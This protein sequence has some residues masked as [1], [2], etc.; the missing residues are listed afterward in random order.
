MAEFELTTGTIESAQKVLIYGQHG[1][2]KT[3]LAAQL[4]GAVLIDVEGGSGHVDCTRYPRPTTW[5]EL[6]YMVADALKRLQPG[7]TLVI[8]SA[9][10]AERLVFEHICFEHSVASIEGINWGK[11]YVYAADEFK[12][13]LRGLDMLIDKG[14]NVVFVAH[15]LITKFDRPDEQSSY[16]VYGLKLSKHIAP[17]VKEWADAVL[18]CRYK[19]IVIKTEDKKSKA[20]GSGERVMQ[21]THTATIDAKNRWGLD[22]EVPMSAEIINQH[23]K[24][25]D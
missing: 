9:D 17:L 19:E 4:P 7:S 10:W 22:G 5:Q 2:G 12:R 11:G 14:V 13:L 25:R 21:T 18:F 24:R 6:R 1:I 15:D 3:T 16:S 20:V 23:L 8:D